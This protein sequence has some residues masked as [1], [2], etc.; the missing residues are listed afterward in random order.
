MFLKII[1]LAVLSILSIFAVSFSYLHAAPS[2]EEM[3]SQGILDQAPIHRDWHKYEDIPWNFIEKETSH[4]RRY[5]LP[6][7][8]ELVLLLIL[9]KDIDFPM[10]RLGKWSNRNDS[11]TLID[12]SGCEVREKAIA[13]CKFQDPR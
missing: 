5:H 2:Y 6:K 11:F 3:R 13:W 7:D 8:D 10:V 4:Q 12:V 1:I 9:D